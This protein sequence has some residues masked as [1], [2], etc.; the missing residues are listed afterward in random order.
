MA[1]AGTA[2]GLNADQEVVML[3]LVRYD[4]WANGTAKDR[5]CVVVPA[6]VSAYRGLR[7]LVSSV[8]PTRGTL[9]LAAP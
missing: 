1:L 6:E 2:P 8:R 7:P 4:Y 5:S 9:C 3:Q